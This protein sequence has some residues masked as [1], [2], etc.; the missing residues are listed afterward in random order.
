MRDPRRCLLPILIA[1][2]CSSTLA[3]VTPLHA[4]ADGAS[5]Y[6]EFFSDGFVRMDLYSPDE[7]THQSFHQIS[8]PEVI[9]NQAY[10][11]FPNDQRLRLG[12]IEYDESGLVGG[13]GDAPITGLT[14]GVGSDPDD[15]SYVNFN[16]FTTNA[17]VDSFSGVVTLVD[18]AP[19]GVTLTSN[20]TLL[21][22]DFLGATIAGAYPGTFTIGGDDF[23]LQACGVQELDTL[24]GTFDVELEWDFSGALHTVGLGD[25]DDDGDV[26]TDD[27]AVWSA[28]Y[29]GTA[30]FGTGADGNAD[31]VVDAA[32]YTIWRD[33]YLEGGGPSAGVPEPASVV[34]AGVGS[35]AALLL[36]PSRHRGRVRR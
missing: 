13:N 21:V 14:L 16:R 19:F 7:P 5:T 36:R 4:I 25:Y 28:A 32:D 33:H 9:Y 35:A 34:V 18:G 22:E 20:V 29:G 31:G 30:P 17:T 23:V 1:S 3:G 11:A 2:L 27:Y 15:P 6:R 24:F 12:S 8:D 10:D 26:D